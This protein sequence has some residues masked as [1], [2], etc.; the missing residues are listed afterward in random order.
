[1]SAAVDVVLCL[2]TEGPCADPGSADLL[3]DWAGVEAAMDKLFDDD[4]RRRHP[5]PAGGGLR[6]GWFFLTW[7]GFATNPRNRDLGYHRVRDR[8]RER[9]GTA[10]DAFGDEECWH[11][12]H[13]PASGVGNEWGLDWSASD[14]HDRILARQLLERD[15]FPAVYRAGGTIMDSVSSRW[16]DRWFPIDYS[17]RAPVAIEGLV[18]WSGGV[19]DWSL[20]HPD[21]EDFRR[22]GAGQR[23]MARCLDLVTHVHALGDDEIDAAFARAAGGLP[24]VLSCF[25]HDYRDIAGRIDDFRERV[26]RAA[27]RY[28]QVPWRYSAPAEAVRRYRGSPPEPPLVLDATV[29]GGVVTLWSTAPVHQA[30]PFVALRRPSGDVEHVEEGLLRLDARRWQWQAAGD[31]TEAAFGLSTPLGTAAVLRVQPGDGGAGAF[32]RRPAQRHPTRPHSI[33]EH[34]KLFAG[35]CADRAAGSAPEMDSVRQTVAWLESRLRPGDTIL[36][37]GAAAGHLSRSLLRLGVE[38]HGIDSHERAIEIGRAQ[39]ANEGLP[40]D[41]L[42]TIPIEELPPDERYDAVV[43]L[44]TLLYVPG[45]HR[46]LENLARAASRFVVVRSLFGA[47]TEVRYLPDV[48]LEPGFESTRAYFNVLGRDEVEA[49]LEREGFRVEWVADERRAEL[50]EV[51]VVGGVA[52]PYEFLF[53]ERVA[54]APEGDEALDELFGEAA[55]AWREERGGW[56]GP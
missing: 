17:N 37:V 42:R 52:H 55:R 1:M 50:G 48:L 28:P 30:V 34:S 43:S 32:L 16:V 49:F 5:D 8:Y 9:W 3:G 23:V 21:P 13:P 51:E 15:W 41:R 53:A 33:W 38:Y 47:T 44:S 10:L 39:L 2:D 35:L 4:F 12:H 19:A 29:A 40:R 22:P 56:S 54:P 27:A 18:D 25:E 46:A 45:W 11:Y 31:W 7:T 26:A 14:E 24:A 20:Y 36:D 6:V